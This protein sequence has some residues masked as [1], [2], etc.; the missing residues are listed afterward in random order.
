MI[1]HIGQKS[2]RTQAAPGLLDQGCSR[3]PKSK[4]ETGVLRR[5]IIEASPNSIESQIREKDLSLWMWDSCVRHNPMSVEKLPLCMYLYMHPC[6]KGSKASLLVCLASLLWRAVPAVK[7]LS[8]KVS[9]YMCCFGW[10]FC[11][12]F[13]R[14][15]YNSELRNQSLGSRSD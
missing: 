4:N 3:G 7:K 5:G 10:Y 11:T 12:K 14:N 6:G 13:H 8:L 2:T 15:P 9:A 1:P